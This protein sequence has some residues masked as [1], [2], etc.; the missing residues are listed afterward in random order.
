[1]RIGWVVLRALVIPVLLV[2]AEA[3]DRAV[4]SVVGV[5]N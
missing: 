1:M 4:G 3:A 2:L 5:C